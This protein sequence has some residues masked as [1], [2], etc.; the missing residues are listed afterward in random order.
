MTIK[1]SDTL[2]DVELRIIGEK[3]PEKKS[4]KELFGGKRVALFA[5]PGAFTAT[6]SNKHAP[7]YISHADELKAKG[8]DAIYCTS[9][10]DIFVLEAWA[11]SMGAGDKITMIADG[12]FEFA[13]GLGLTF[14]GSAFGMG[15]RSQRYSMIV[16][17]GVVEQLFTEKPGTYELS[18]AE[19]MLQNL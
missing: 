18:S 3:G 1:P 4:V 16:S 11:T 15:E 5:V 10:T 9:T 14:D 6:C 19:H 2:P 13:R 8:I 12:N 7:S 17:D